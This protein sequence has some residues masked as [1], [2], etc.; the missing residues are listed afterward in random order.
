MR[1]GGSGVALWSLWAGGSGV[2][3]LSLCAGGS[4][5]A[6]RSLCAGGS[7]VAL[8][9]RCPRR[10]WIARF[11]SFLVEIEWFLICEPRIK[12]PAQAAPP[13]RA[14][15]NASAAI[16]VAGCRRCLNIRASSE[17]ALVEPCG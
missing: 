1:A 6:L 12:P 4:G 16:T 3:F 7:C 9:P 15:N 5:V 13:P 10:E 2:A 14:T 8:L 17:K 11:V